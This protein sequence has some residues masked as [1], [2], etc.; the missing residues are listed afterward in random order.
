VLAGP[1]KSEICREAADW[2]ADLIV[3][4]SRGRHGLGALVNLTEDAVLHGAPC[5]ILAVRL[6]DPA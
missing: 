4:G 6:Q 1:I 3:I 2:H 5:D